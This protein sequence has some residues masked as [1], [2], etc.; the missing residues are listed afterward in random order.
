MDRKI[1]IFLFYCFLLSF[2]SREYLVLDLEVVQPRSVLAVVA[3]DVEADGL[4]LD[5]QLGDAH[6]GDVLLQRASKCKA[7]AQYATYVA[8][9]VDAVII[10]VA[11]S[12]AAA[13][14]VVVV[15]A[16]AAAF[17]SPAAAAGVLLLLLLLPALLLLLLQLRQQHD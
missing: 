2:A 11:S 1:D 13:A 17:A 4:G 14:V 5:I 10:G 3:L 9:A 12:A 15:V 7:A 6:H 16:V 8:T